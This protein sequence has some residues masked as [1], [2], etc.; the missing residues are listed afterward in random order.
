MPLPALATL[1]QLEARVGH[2]LESESDRVEAIL[3]DA[4]TLVR[5]VAGQTWVDSEGELEEDIPDAVILVVLSVARRAYD[6]PQGYIATT[7]GPFSQ[8]YTEEAAQVLYLTD[9]EKDLIGGTTNTSGLWALS[10]TRGDLE[11][12]VALPENLDSV[13]T[14]ET[15]SA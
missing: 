15:D 6:N 5:S 8:R 12:R 4:S 13:S 2:N 3:A 9:T 1:A 7:D 14:F 10:T 11:T